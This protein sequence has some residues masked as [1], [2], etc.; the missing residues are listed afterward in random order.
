MGE[1]FVQRYNLQLQTARMRRSVQ[2][3]AVCCARCVSSSAMSATSF[4]VESKSRLVPVSP[5]I[6][7][8]VYRVWTMAEV[9]PDQ[10][11]QVRDEV[12][13]FLREGDELIV[14]T[15]V[16]LGIQVQIVC[17]HLKVRRGVWPG[18]GRG[19]F[20]N[21][22]RLVEL[23]LREILVVEVFC[24]VFDDRERR[25]GRGSRR[26]SQLLVGWKGWSGWWRA[27]CCNEAV[28]RDT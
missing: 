5:L 4:E 9:L 28:V 10:Q 15:R 3:P 7:E 1:L 27:R 23:R 19:V 22:N 20:T 18:E 14:L 6:R 8:G 2:S 13:H 12:R 17:S 11:A 25:T 24:G 16:L 26:G 21:E